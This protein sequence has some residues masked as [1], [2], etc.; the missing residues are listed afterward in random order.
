MFFDK[1]RMKGFKYIPGESIEEAARKTGLPPSKIIKLCSNE[2]PFG[3]S[4]MVKNAIV[5][6]VDEVRLYPDPKGKELKKAISSY[7]GIP[8]K[9]IVLGNGTDG[10]ID[11]LMKVFVSAKDRV[12]IPVPTFSYYEIS[13]RS[14]GAVPK[15]VRRDK[16]FDVNVKRI[17]QMKGKLF[18][19][20][21]PNNPTGNQMKEDDLRLILESKD[22]MVI[23]D[24]AYVEFAPFS[25]TKL[26]RKY[27][28][29]VVLR[30][31]SKAFGLAGLRIGYA[32]VHPECAELY[33][34]VS[35]PFAVNRLGM[36]AA[37]AALGDRDYMRRTVE[38]IKKGREFL[39]EKIPFKAFPSCANFVLV[40]VSPRKAGDVCRKM[41]KKG[42]LL[43]DCSSFRGAGES[44][45]RVT[46]GKMEENE[47]VVEE[48]NSL[49][50]SKTS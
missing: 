33:E 48:L 4:P 10:V 45:V 30:S 3:C 47:K 17:L 24:E 22:S 34:S 1:M 2:N 36:V 40:D 16:N 28:N 31:F 26:V 25:L 43:R 29:L 11:T 12:V 18:F 21:S 38:K 15:F 50:H 14:I 42:I 9:N 19:L 7:I 37:I 23:L 13:A 8:G 44:L 39:L 6:A 5:K 35:P 41:M 20:C 46:V 32:V 49:R 27:E